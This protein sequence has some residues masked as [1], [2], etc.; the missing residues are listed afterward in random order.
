[1][2]RHSGD[3]MTLL[4]DRI[5]EYLYENEA[6]SPTE[7]M[8]G[9]PINFS[10]AYIGRRCKKLKENGLLREISDATYVI[11]DDGEAYL[12]GQLD[13]ENWRYIGGDDSEVTSS[14][15]EEVPSESKGE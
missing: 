15:S 3:W 9:G 13:T 4:D 12:E 6:A 10:R 14:S 7:M 5:L 8:K 11:T 1:M 2:L